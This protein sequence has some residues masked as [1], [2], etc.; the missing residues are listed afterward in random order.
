MFD[1]IRGLAVQRGP[2]D[3]YLSDR[4]IAF[5]IDHGLGD[6]RLCVDCVTTLFGLINGFG[7]S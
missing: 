6:A 3:V 2:I 5:D 1:Y 4:H 7:S